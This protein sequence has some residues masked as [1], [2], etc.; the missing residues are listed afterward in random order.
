M[1]IWTNFQE[2]PSKAENNDKRDCMY[3]ENLF[4][5]ASKLILGKI[6]KIMK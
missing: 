4:K 2:T 5:Y 3:L 6:K 1:T